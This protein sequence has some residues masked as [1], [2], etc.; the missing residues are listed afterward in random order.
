MVLIM[1]IPLTNVSSAHAVALLAT[2]QVN[3]LFNAILATTALTVSLDLLNAFNVQLVKSL[4]LMLAV[5]KL[6][7]LNAHAV[8]TMIPRLAPARTVQQ[9]A[10]HVLQVN[11]A[12]LAHQAS[13][14]NS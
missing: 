10:V 2:L 8:N 9:I 6:V 3:A 1:T 14:T 5:T 7:K 11:I 12:T 4:S 13:S